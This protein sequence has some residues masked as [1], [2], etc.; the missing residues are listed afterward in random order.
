M[1]PH[2]HTLADT[3]E[4]VEII[5]TGD[6]SPPVEELSQH[7]HDGEQASRE[8]DKSAVGSTASLM[9]NENSTKRTESGSQLLEK[10]DSGSP[11]RT[12]SHLSGKTGSETEGSEC[13]VMSRIITEQPLEEFTSIPTKGR[14]RNC[15]KE[16][17][18]LESAGHCERAPN[19]YRFQIDNCCCVKAFNC[20]WYHLTKDN[21]QEHLDIGR[22]DIPSLSC[23]QWALFVTLNVLC[24]P[25]L[26]LWCPLNLCEHLASLAGITG[27]GRHDF[28]HSKEGESYR[29]RN[30]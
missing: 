18:C 8:S 24:F 28:R 13:S 3:S 10:K 27:T 4:H 14:C 2:Q 29:N 1:C 30:V 11:D 23:G 26:C 12:V 16:F 17:A 21:L 7:E 19:N 20:P 15:F 5:E 6:S 25:C 22:C 9:S